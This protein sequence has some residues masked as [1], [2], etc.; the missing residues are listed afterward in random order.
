MDLA[1]YLRVARVG[2]LVAI[3]AGPALAWMITGPV[4][5]FE[6]RRQADFPALEAVVAPEMDGRTQLADAVIER[7]WA[8]RTALTLRSGFD[9]LLFGQADVALAV[10][11][12]DGWLFYRPQFDAW[13]CENLD[14]SRNGIE[15]LITQSE[16]AA[17][18]EVPI[19][20]A[21]AP[22]KAS[23]ERDYLGGRA[24]RVIDSCYDIV[25]SELRTAAREDTTGLIVDHTALLQ[26]LE[27]DE[28][29]FYR[30]DT[31]WRPRAELAAFNQL[32]GLA[33]HPTGVPLEN[34]EFRSYDKDTDIAGGILSL[35][36]RER[37][38][39]PLPTPVDWEQVD[40]SSYPGTV[41]VSHDSFY[42]SLAPVFEAR[43][44]NPVLAHLGNPHSADAGQ[45]VETADFVIVERVERNLLRQM[46]SWASVAGERDLYRWMLERNSA[47][48]QHC[49]WDE[50]LDLM[51]A[52]PDA[53]T[54][55]RR[56]EVLP[57]GGVV[58]SGT[59]SRVHFRV[60]A[61]WAG[62]PVCMRARV[63]VNLEEDQSWMFLP[64]PR[65]TEGRYAN[66]R[67][68]H[69]D[70][71]KGENE[72]QLVLPESVVNQHIRWDP[73]RSR[74]PVTVTALEIAPRFAR[75]ASPQPD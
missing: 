57:G 6:G 24:A 1:K 18:G 31:H 3:M 59:N 75:G 46:N 40:V 4:D 47:T 14:V 20:F 9:Y 23:V 52:N 69:L 71:H 67:S 32:T 43:F 53:G 5:P 17:A 51:P 48:A 56:M 2:I 30:T 16:F 60:P 68:L 49:A 65:F 66:G 10:S 22:N 41:L 35:P 61:E 11:G 44:R 26:A 27:G 29:S 12:E 64:G 50:A 33:D 28:P 8:R 36:V 45:A 25:E 38:Q 39:R 72:I 74:E 21:I 19:L 55:F 34:P 37:V 58:T 42:Q 70:L 15:A 54:D 62:A 7:S 73:T 63:T 13:N